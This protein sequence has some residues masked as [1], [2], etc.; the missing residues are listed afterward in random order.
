VLPGSDLGFLQ[1]AASAT[2]T[3]MRGLL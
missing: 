2:A 1:S 3:A